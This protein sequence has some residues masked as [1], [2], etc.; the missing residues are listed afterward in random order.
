MLTRLASKISIIKLDFEMISYIEN[1]GLLLESSSQTTQKITKR[2]EI[3][4]FINLT[5][6]HFFKEV[7][8]SEQLMSSLLS[9][10]ELVRMRYDSIKKCAE[11]N[12]YS[13]VYL[14]T[15]DKQFNLIKILVLNPPKEYHLKQHQSQ[16]LII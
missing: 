15:R 5:S 11:I 4:S 8:V 13:E 16:R 3:I 2:P 14:V 10:S 1:A 7:N 9:I 6:K 12:G